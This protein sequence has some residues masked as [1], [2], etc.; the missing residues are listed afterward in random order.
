MN[1]V[2]TMP[3]MAAIQMVSGPDVAENL[4]AAAELLAQIG[5]AHV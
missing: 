2:N 3:I 5:R 1:E 4:A